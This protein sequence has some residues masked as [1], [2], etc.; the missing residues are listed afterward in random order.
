M[1]EIATPVFGYKNHINVDRRFGLI[2]K[3][4]VTDAAAYDEW[5]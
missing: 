4:A 3:W 5:P 2:R 1:A